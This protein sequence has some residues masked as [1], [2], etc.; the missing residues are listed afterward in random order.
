MNN[1]QRRKTGLSGQETMCRG[2]NAQ[3]GLLVPQDVVEAKSQRYYGQ[4][5]KAKHR[6]ELLG[7]EDSTIVLTYQLEYR[8][9]ANYYQLAHNIYHLG[10]LKWVMEISL[11]KTLAAKHKLTA[12]KVRKKYGAV[13]TVQGKGIQSAPSQSAKRRKT[14]ASGDMGWYPLKTEY[15]GNLRGKDTSPMEQSNRTHPS[16]SRGLL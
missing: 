4:E 14:P 9:I 16:A 6:T 5:K 13:L 2:I 1:A 7:Y 8:G 12:S 3:I 10:K 11:T 15:E